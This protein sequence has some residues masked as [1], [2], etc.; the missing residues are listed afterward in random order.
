[1]D[2]S[3]HKAVDV[4]FFNFQKGISELRTVTFL[5]VRSWDK[6][7]RFPGFLEAKKNSIGAIQSDDSETVH[8]PQNS[9]LH[10]K[11]TG[12]KSWLYHS[13]TDFEQVICAL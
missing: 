11:C 8:L 3:P 6:Q 10:W 9:G 5:H 13:L 1:M 2:G 12:Q 7:E 4:F